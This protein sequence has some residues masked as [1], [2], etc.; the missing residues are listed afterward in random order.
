MSKFRKFDDDIVVTANTY[1]GELA[2]PYVAAATTSVPT[3]REG[4]CR[5]IEGVVSKAV[6]SEVVV[7]DPLLAANCGFDPGDKLSIDEQVLTTT[8]LR[9]NEQICRGTIF[10]T[11]VAANGSMNRDGDLPGDFEAFMMAQ[12]AAKAGEHLEKLIWTGAS[13]FGTGFLS[14]DGT[15]DT[16]ATGIP[17]SA[18]GSFTAAEFDSAYDATNIDDALNALWTSVAGANPAL[19][20][21]PGFGIYM[22]WEA[23]GFY[24]QWLSST[25][26][27]YENRLA[28]QGYQ[29]VNYLGLP[30][31]PTYGI[32]NTVDVMVATYP[33][34]LVVGTNNYTPDASARVIPTYL[35]DGSDHIRV[36]MNFAVGVQTAVPTD[37]AVLFNH[38]A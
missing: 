33:E 11:W 28:N 19:L 2:A 7:A 4:R 36:T 37:G 24:L 17:G 10:P 22:S 12:V 38:V 27:G 14:T 34:N 9:V 8:D 1:A 23:Y 13:P 35:Y 18:C 6:I 20:E 30:V 25:G 32:P 15:I 3:I 26:S 5:L 21:K 29:G 31:Y 16:D